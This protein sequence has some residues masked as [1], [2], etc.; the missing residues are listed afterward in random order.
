MKHMKIMTAV[1]TVLFIF[2]FSAVA[3][4]GSA[5]AQ[6]KESKKLKQ[7]PM[8][9][10]KSEKNQDIYRAS[11]LVGKAVKNPEGESLGDINDIVIDPQD[12]RIAYAVLSFGGVLGVG[13]KLFAV[14]WK[15]FRV[16]TDNDVLVLNVDK[17]RLKK[18]PG[19]DKN[20]WPNLSDRSYE[21]KVYSYYGQRPYWKSKAKVSANSSR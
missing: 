18:A 17:D 9:S 7:E 2:A 8:S 12:G 6:E 14:P 15:S 19:F 11:K 4:P 3:I 13:D 10:A 16:D 21:A 1:A 5:A 20:N